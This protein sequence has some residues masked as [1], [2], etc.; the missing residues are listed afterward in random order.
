M[1]TGR[2][3]DGA[4][5]GQG[6]SGAAKRRPWC[7]LESQ[8]RQCAIRG[9]GQLRIRRTIGATVRLHLVPR[10]PVAAEDVLATLREW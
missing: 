6:R 4:P 5:P 7:E 3:E 10:D 8:V 9:I 1:Q 2:A